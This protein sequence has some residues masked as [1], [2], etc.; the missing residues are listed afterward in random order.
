M[1]FGLCFDAIQRNGTHNQY[2][3]GGTQLSKHHTSASGFFRGREAQSSVRYS[4]RATQSGRNGRMTGVGKRR[5]V[6][7]THRNVWLTRLNFAV[8]HWRAAAAAMARPSPAVEESHKIG[9]DVGL[10]ESGFALPL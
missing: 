8:A 4:G 6:S 10:A 7:L 5:T 1:F 9:R 2:G 3:H